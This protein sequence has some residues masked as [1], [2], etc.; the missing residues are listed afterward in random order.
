[1]NSVKRRGA[2]KPNRRR[3]GDRGAGEEEDLQSKGRQ[4][5]GGGAGKEGRTVG[6]MVMTLKWVLVSMIKRMILTMMN[7]M[8]TVM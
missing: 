1:M 4:V 6:M 5:R 3:R 2:S 7:L 8:S